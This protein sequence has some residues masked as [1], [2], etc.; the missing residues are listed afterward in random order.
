MGRA[1]RRRAERR[2]AV[3]T[4]VPH[5]RTRATTPEPALQPRPPTI[6]TDDV[7]VTAPAP[8][9]IPQSHVEPAGSPVNLTRLAD[10]H[11]ERQELD[12][13]ITLF[14]ARLAAAG[15]SWGAIGRALGV[16]RQG[17]RQRYG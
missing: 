13:Q 12:A 8:P 7:P 5:A 10:L 16:S 14:V 17:A 11:D 4:W 15:V 1:S 2:T 3:V 9:P 6:R